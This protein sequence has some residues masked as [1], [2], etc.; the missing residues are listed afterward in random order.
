[1]MNLSDE[2]G[3]VGEWRTGKQIWNPLGTKFSS[4]GTEA[5]TSKE[6]ERIPFPPGLSAKFK[7]E[8]ERRGLRQID[9][10]TMTGVAAHFVATAERQPVSM[11]RIALEPLLELA[12]SWGVV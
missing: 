12:E 6:Y 2:A 5:D 10:S 1:M 3:K 4:D 11:A 9:I 8:R 7:E